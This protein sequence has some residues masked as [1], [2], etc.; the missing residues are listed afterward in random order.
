M[1]DNRQ[2]LD[3]LKSYHMPPEAVKLLSDSKPLMIAGV[4]SAGKNSVAAYLAQ[5]SNYKHVVSHTTRPPRSTEENGKNYWFVSNGEMMRLLESGQMIEAN[6]VHG[7]TIYGT[8]ISA[9]RSVVNSGHKP[10]LVIDVQG[11]DQITLY[12]PDLSA[13]FLLPPS[14]EIWMERLDKRGMMSHVERERRLKSARIEIEHVL[15]SQHFVLYVNRE[16]NTVAQAIQKGV[17]IHAEQHHNRELAL[18]LIDHIKA[19]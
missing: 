9:Y 14:F 12:V 13:V 1:A 16:V 3:Q 6:A 15:R 5:S 2:L 4:T 8:S 19:Y 10:L 17:I 18:R 7:E 11:V